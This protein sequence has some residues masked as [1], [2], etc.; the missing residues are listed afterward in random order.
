ME[1]ASCVFGAD[2]EVVGGGGGNKIGEV[3]GGEGCADGLAF[4]GGG[5]G[6]PFAFLPGARVGGVV[7]FG[8]LKWVGG[9]GA[10]GLA[11][12]FE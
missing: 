3:G 11:G 5:E 8:G 7:E 1:L 10:E 2:A 4:D 6:G 12:C 9:F